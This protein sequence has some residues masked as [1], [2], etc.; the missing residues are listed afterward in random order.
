MKTMAAKKEFDVFFSQLFDSAAG[1]LQATALYG[2]WKEKLE[3][4]ELD[5]TTMFTADEQAFAAECFALLTEISKE[6]EAY[7]YRKGLS[8]CVCLLKE[9]GVL[10]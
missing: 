1:E 2:L 7:L 4:M 10:A 6:E 8:D 5:C 9:L 3:Q